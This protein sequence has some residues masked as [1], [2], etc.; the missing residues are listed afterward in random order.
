[1]DGG[2]WQAIVDRVAESDAT[3]HAAQVPFLM[4]TMRFLLTLSG[5]RKHRAC[6]RYP[7]VSREAGHFP[8]EL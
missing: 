8:R 7:W 3:E 4:P 6:P 1:M 2:A 5:F